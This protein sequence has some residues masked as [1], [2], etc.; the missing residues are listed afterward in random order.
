MRN[1][2]TTSRANPEAMPAEKE[3]YMKVASSLVSRVGLLA[4]GFSAGVW[5]AIARTQGLPLELRVSLIAI[6][7][8]ALF[9]GAF[10][11]CPRGQQ[12]EGADKG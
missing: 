8:A 5:L 12:N 10:S 9:V 4:L 6:S 1:P 7:V 11:L 3:V 2:E